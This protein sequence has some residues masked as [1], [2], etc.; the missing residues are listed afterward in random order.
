MV[1]LAVR[2]ASSAGGTGIGGA[3]NT[4]AATDTGIEVILEEEDEETEI[5]IDDVLW[6]RGHTEEEWI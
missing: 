5:I 1:K 4:P 6:W 2:R 3:S